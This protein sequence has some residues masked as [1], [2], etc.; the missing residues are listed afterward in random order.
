MWEGSGLREGH[1][2]GAG[3][4]GEC[5]VGGEW[6]EGGACGDLILIDI[7]KSVMK[8]VFRLFTSM[9]CNIWLCDETVF[10]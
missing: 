5:D 10:L 7:I 2:G 1:V 8:H 6:V 3:G 9:M 4:A